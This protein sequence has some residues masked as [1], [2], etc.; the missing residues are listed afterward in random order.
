MSKKRLRMREENTVKIGRLL[1]DT[2]RR[3]N[4]FDERKNE[5]ISRYELTSYS[6]S[7]GRRLIDMAD[8]DLSRLLRGG[9]K[10]SKPISARKMRRDSK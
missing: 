3:R 8:V 1:E 7:N 6:P 2:I 4:I 9:V 5:Y 10:F